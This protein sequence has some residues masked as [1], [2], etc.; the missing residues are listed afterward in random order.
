MHRDDITPRLGEITCPSLVIHGTAD[1]AIPFLKAEQLRDLLGG[2]TTLV[3]ID[4][5]PHAANMTHPEP[6]NEAIVQFLKSLD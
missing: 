1:A 5:G 6:V 4:G 2:S 3:A